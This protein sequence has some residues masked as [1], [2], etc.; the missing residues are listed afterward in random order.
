MMDFVK[1]IILPILGLVIL[2]VWADYTSKQKAC[3]LW[4]I[5]TRRETRF[6]SD[7][8]WYWDCIVKTDSGWVSAGKFEVRENNINN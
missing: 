1:I 8:P 4:G 3:S 5:E 2:L 6:I 7:I